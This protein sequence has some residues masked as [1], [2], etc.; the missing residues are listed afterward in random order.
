MADHKVCWSQLGRMI[1]ELSYLLLLPQKLAEPV[2]GKRGDKFNHV[3]VPFLQ[4][5]S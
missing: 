3:K 1:A 4:I 5:Y 2:G